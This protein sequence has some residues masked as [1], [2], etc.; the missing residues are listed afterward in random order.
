MA[1]SQCFVVEHHSQSY[2]NCYSHDCISHSQ[3]WWPGSQNLSLL[4]PH[5]SLPPK[6]LF[7]ASMTIKQ[8]NLISEKSSSNHFLKNVS[9][10]GFPNISL[11]WS[12]TSILVSSKTPFSFP[13][14]N[15]PQGV[16]FKSALEKWPILAQVTGKGKGLRDLRPRNWNW[17]LHLPGLLPS[18]SISRLCLPL[19]MSVSLIPS[20]CKETLL[21]WWGM[22][23]GAAHL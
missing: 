16:V 5:L 3:M 14:E 20:Y 2:G 15:I 19:P 18:T 10:L 11:F 7:L 9:A 23:P 12:F 8:S 6:P 17:T 1:E 22:C 4:L 13:Q 21:I